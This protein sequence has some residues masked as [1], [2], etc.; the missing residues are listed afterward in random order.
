[1]NELVKTIL[2]TN[3]KGQLAGADIGGGIVMA[4]APGIGKT[5]TIYGLAKDLDMN[6][7]QVSI[8]EL[9]TENLSG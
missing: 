5:Q 1:M 9:S 2:K 3:I 6:V 7:V 4:G 8:P